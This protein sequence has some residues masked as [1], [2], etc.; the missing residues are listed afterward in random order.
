[1]RLG[2]QSSLIVVLALGLTACSSFSSLTA[3][4]KVDYK[5]QGEVR[6][7]NLALPP[8]LITAQADRRFIVQDGTATMSEY[9]QAVKKSSQMRTNV[10]TGIPGMKI[11][12][13]GDKR[14]LV[15]DK[16]AASLYPQIKD[17]WQ[18]NGFLLLIDSPSTG[19]METDW[20]ENRTKIPEDIIRRTL[21]KVLDS[22]YDSGERDKFRTRLEV[23]KPE[24]T[25]IY[26]SHK[27]AIEV[28]L[29]DAST[30][31]STR[32]TVRPSDPE[33]EAIFL[34]RLMERL[35]MTQEQA[36]AQI[37]TTAAAPKTPKAKL[38]ED[39]AETRI[40]MTQS[41]DRAWR[42]VGLALDRSNFTV[43][44]R[45]R[46]KGI[47]F[48]RYVNPKDLGDSRGWFGRTFG[49]TDD[50]DKKAKVYRVVVQD[51]GQN[52]I[53]ISV[54]DSDGKPENTATG[55]QLLTTLDRQLIK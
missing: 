8:D 35:G 53:V 13:D 23:Q 30:T 26:I 33:L 16:S 43:D 22:L 50:A 15:V 14:W 10:L 28:P 5:K 40:E 45:D 7:P 41:F 25:E 52:Q 2:I 31:I 32:W 9:S 36:K 48:V 12:R 4:D 3:S 21:G 42:D 51:R 20:A 34:T 39:G 1:M 11:E 6:G 29:K 18:E 49:K 17:F 38:I 54:Q 44:D 37:T 24:V 19:I 47:Y 27:G 55:N 46:S